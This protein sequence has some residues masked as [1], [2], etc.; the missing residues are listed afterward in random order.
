MVYKLTNLGHRCAGVLWAPVTGEATYASSIFQHF[1]IKVKQMLK[2]CAFKWYFNFVMTFRQG[3]PCKNIK[4]WP[5]SIIK[6]VAN[7]F[8]AEK[9]YIIAQLFRRINTSESLV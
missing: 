4:L 7:K 9:M 1:I 3:F 2:Y 8:Q 5:V 6:R